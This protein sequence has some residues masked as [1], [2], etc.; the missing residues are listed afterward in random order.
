MK[1]YNLLLIIFC[2]CTA[3][4]AQ[5]SDNRNTLNEDFLQRWN[6][7]L[8]I[9]Q[10]ERLVKISVSIFDNKEQNTN[11]T[12][13]TSLESFPVPEISIVYNDPATGFE[14]FQSNFEN[15]PGDSTFII[16]SF[17]FDNII[18]EANAFFKNGKADKAVEYILVNIQEILYPKE[19]TET[20]EEQLNSSDKIYYLYA[21]S[22]FVVIFLIITIRKKKKPKNENRSYLFNPMSK[23]DF[24]GGGFDSI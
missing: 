1:K 13:S 17:F 2:V 18:P 4:F 8:S 24:F 7:I 21:I 12:D 3:V 14:I 19:F 15:F 16:P 23:D 6:E 11:Q 9:T 5:I 10:A 20:N 22:I